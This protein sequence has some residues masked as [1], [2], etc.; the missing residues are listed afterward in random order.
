M[1]LLHNT[2]FNAAAIFAIFVLVANLQLFS[3]SVSPSSCISNAKYL[4][5]DLYF[6][7]FPSKTRFYFVP[8]LKFSIF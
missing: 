2:E 6:F 5:L 1:S 3:L 7:T 4:K 8:E